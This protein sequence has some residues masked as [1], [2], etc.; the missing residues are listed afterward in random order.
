MDDDRRLRAAAHAE[1]LESLRR[2]GDH[3]SPEELLAYQEGS[4][5]AAERD[6]LQEHLAGCRECA[7]ALLDL[8]AFPQLPAGR[9]EERLG[10]EDLE[11]E[12]QRFA[13]AIG[14]A[15]PR[16]LA[17]AR[18]WGPWATT[19]AARL[20]Y[21]LAAGLLVV[22]VGLAARVARL[23]SRL[24]ELSQPQ[25]NVYLGDLVPTA[26]ARQ[27]GEGPQQALHVPPEAD[28]LLLLLNLAD[29]RVYP[30]YEVEIS[31]ARGHPVWSRAGLRRSPEG[32]FTLELPRG[33]LPAGSYRLRL[34]GREGN[35]RT[36]VVDYDFTIDYQ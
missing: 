17:V 12:W 14:E 15:A 22:A 27:R 36:P 6:R 31:D 29:S 24:A 34:A 35:E 1:A 18:R 2:G 9:S 21:A 33:F 28:R 23:E 3:P 11:R 20:A 16:P 30:E 8:A 26:A 32:T 19:P 25:L 5:P 4:Q 13:V 7:G 10:A